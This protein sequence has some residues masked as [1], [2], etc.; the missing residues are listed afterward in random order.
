MKVSWHHLVFW[1]FCSTPVFAQLSESID[2]ILVSGTQIPLRVQETGRSITI[3]RQDAIQQMPAISID[4]ILQLVPGVEVQSRNGFGAQADILMRGSTF[5]QVLI[6]VDGMRLNDP[7][8][9]HFNGNIP[10]PNAEIE[11]IEVLRGPAAAM[12]GPDAVGGLINIVTKTFNQKQKPGLNL[13]GQAGVGSNNQILGEATFSHASEIFSGSIAAQINKSDGELVPSMATDNGAL[14]AYRNYFDIKTVGAAM[15]LKMKNDLTLKLRSSYDYRDFNARYFY[16]SSN[17]DKSTE[18]T[19]NSFTV[20]QLDKIRNNASSNLQIGYRY[21][22]DEFV[23][24]PDFAS[25]NNHKSHHLNVVTNHLWNLSGQFVFK[26]GA[27]VDRRSIISNDRGDHQDWHLGI[28]TMGL[29]QPV[30]DFSMTGG[31]RLDYDENY[32]IEVLPQISLSYNLGS[33]LVRGS[34]GRSI[35]A[36]DYTERYVSNNL[37]NLTPG[38]SLG[39]PDLLAESSWSEEL[40][41]DIFIGNKLQLKTTGFFRQSKQLID[42]VSTN[43]SE[44]GDIGDLQAGADY[45]FAKNITDVVTR[46]LELEAIFRHNFGEKRSLTMTAGY[47]RQMTE[48]EDGVVSVYI[49]NH[50]KDLANFSTLVSLGNINFALAGLYKNRNARVAQTINSRLEASY[51]LWNLKA[52]YQIASNWSVHFLIQNIFDKSYQNILGAPMPGRWLSGKISWNF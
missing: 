12:F 25:T 22:T 4:E 7:L 47:T 23:F 13:S 37:A 10:V 38:R 39:N 42:Y 41:V 51:M 27:Q 19:T 40:G 20:L 18:K 6:L 33:Y 29:F 5:T 43:E 16:T 24:S 35:R 28:Y 3:I 21:N 30:A 52:G 49:A 45:F 9:G 31:L 2:T 1:L 11:R 34:V 8:T 17:F 26:A 36:A 32:D 50:A 48:N 44:I 14:E 46:G 15:A